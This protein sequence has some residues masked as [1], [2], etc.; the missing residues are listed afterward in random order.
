[1]VARYRHRSSQSR[2]TRAA[3]V[4]LSSSRESA[5]RSAATDGRCWHCAVDLRKRGGGCWSTTAATGRAATHLPHTCAP[6]S[7]V[8]QVGR[9]TLSQ[10]RHALL[11][12]VKRASAPRTGGRRSS[13]VSSGK[14]GLTCT[15][16]LASR[17][18]VVGGRRSGLSTSRA[19]CGPP[20]PA[21]PRLRV[22]TWPT[23]VNSS[24]PAPA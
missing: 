12:T 21:D 24:V 10:T 11:T 16:A 7:L 15:N 23:T 4:R 17:L 19:I 2:A 9:I 20:N 18:S 6:S 22:K 5:A 1:M 8:G 13:L 14:W 3:S